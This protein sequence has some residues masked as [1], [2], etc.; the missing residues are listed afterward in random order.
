MPADA[1]APPAR[2]RRIISFERPP[3]GSTTFTRSIRPGARCVATMWLK[4]TSGPARVPATGGARRPRR[5]GR[6]RNPPPG[7]ARADWR[8]TRP[9]APPA[10]DPASRPPYALQPRRAKGPSHRRHRRTRLG[11]ARSPRRRPAGPPFRSDEGREGR[12]ERGSSATAEW[13]RDILH[14][15]SLRFV[16]ARVARSCATMAPLWSSDGGGSRGSSPNAA[17]SSRRHTQS[18]FAL[19]QE[20]I[21]HDE[22][23]PQRRF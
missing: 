6:A 11:A 2:R 14:E 15:A 19:V 13:G 22:S 7:C 1:S 8:A 10:V 20:T 16:V 4:P 12:R 5:R 18:A 3:G 9:R 17:P 23:R 21:D